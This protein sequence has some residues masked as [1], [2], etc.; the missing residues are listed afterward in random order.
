VS[1]IDITSYLITHYGCLAIFTLLMPGIFGIP[2]SDELMLTLAGYLVSRGQLSLAPTI[3]AASLGV[4]AGLSLNYVVGRTVGASLFERCKFIYRPGFAKLNG[5][6]D[7]FNHRG[8]WVLFFGYF[9]PGVRHWVSIGA[10]ISKFPSA[11]F[12]L[13][14]YSSSLIWPAFYVLLGYFLGQEQ[15]DI[16]AKICTH[17]QIIAAALIF[18]LAACFLVRERLRSKGASTLV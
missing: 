17:L 12:A 7:R 2:V 5:L 6:K 11:P 14:T 1:V 13:F 18:L 16:S 10:G 3:L 8:G 15:F 4:I 9:L